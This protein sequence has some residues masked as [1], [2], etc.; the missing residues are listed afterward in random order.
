MVLLNYVSFSCLQW[1]VHVLLE[2]IEQKMIGVEGE[3]VGEEGEGEHQ[4]DEPVVETGSLGLAETS[5]VSWFPFQPVVLNTFFPWILEIRNAC[6]SL[7][8]IFHIH[9]YN[10]VHVHVHVEIG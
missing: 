5:A 3:E 9:M 10:D 6:T 2:L 7:I 1:G 8:L 4:W